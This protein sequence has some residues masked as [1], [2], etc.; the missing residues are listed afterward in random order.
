MRGDMSAVIHPA[1]LFIV[2]IRSCS[3]IKIS[4]NDNE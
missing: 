4:L 2:T 1:L 3:W